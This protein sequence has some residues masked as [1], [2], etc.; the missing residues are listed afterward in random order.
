[1]QTNEQITTEN[2]SRGIAEEKGEKRVQLTG[3]ERSRAHR[4]WY[5]ANFGRSKSAVKHVARHTTQYDD[6]LRQ[7]AKK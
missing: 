1:M 5:R 6:H 4:E 7:L 3:K 2:V